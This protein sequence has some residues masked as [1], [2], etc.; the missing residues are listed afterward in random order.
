MLLEYLVNAGEQRNWD[1]N[2]ERLSCFEIDREFQRGRLNDRK[3]GGLCPLDDLT[4]I[5]VDLP[6]RIRQI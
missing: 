1:L 5:V 2:A 6:V 3:V 4:N